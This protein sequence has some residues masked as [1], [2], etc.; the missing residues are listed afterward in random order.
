[1]LGAFLEMDYKL[2]GAQNSICI[3]TCYCCANLDLSVYEET[4]SYISQCMC[5]YLTVETISIYGF[6]YY[7]PTCQRAILQST[8]GGRNGWLLLS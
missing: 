1:M 5:K 4:K 3:A 6:S 8:V 7:S 2:I